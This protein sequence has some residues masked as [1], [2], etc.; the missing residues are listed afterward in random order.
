MDFLFSVIGCLILA[1]I[2]TIL[3]YVFGSKGKPGESN[4]MQK[5][6][7]TF[8]VLFI[9]VVIVTISDTLGCRYDDDFIPMRRN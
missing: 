7:G 6:T 3:R 1:L 8:F 2:I 9:I 4:F 5:F